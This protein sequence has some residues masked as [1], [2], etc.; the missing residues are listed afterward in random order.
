MPVPDWYV[1]SAENGRGRLA[2]TE[3]RAAGRD[4]REGTPSRG[5]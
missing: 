1:G 4:R 5:A 2:R 3:P